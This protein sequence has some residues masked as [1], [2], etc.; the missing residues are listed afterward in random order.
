MFLKM[1]LL[2]IL[3]I[4]TISLAETPAQR[5][6]IQLMGKSFLI[7]CLNYAVRKGDRGPQIVSY[8]QSQA[9]EFLKELRS[10]EPPSKQGND[11]EDTSVASVR[12]FTM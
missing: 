7:G 3:M 2:S 4:P 1:T 10:P 9:N 5:Q 12:K 8:C 11:D 6:V